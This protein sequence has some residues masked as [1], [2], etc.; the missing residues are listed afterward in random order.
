MA[1]PFKKVTITGTITS[2]TV[3]TD[4]AEP[5]PYPIIDTALGITVSYGGT[6][7]LTPGMSIVFFS[8]LVGITAGVVYY[9]LE[10]D[11]SSDSFKISETLDG[12]VKLATDN[13]SRLTMFAAYMEFESSDGP[14]MIFDTNKANQGIVDYTELVRLAAGDGIHTI[15]PYEYLGLIN[16]YKTLVEQG[17]ILKPAT[18]QKSATKVAAEK[19]SDYLNIIKNLPKQF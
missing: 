6:H 5:F 12:D 4:E 15:G 13:S 7:R 19:I 17:D 1:F 14:A 16:S 2:V 3:T 9:I 10:E 11:F 8:D 18:I